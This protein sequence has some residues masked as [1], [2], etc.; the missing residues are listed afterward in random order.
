M[1]QRSQCLAY[2]AKK[3]NY[4]TRDVYEESASSTTSFEQFL[5]S[6][7]IKLTASQSYSLLFIFVKHCILKHCQQLNF[8]DEDT[9]KNLLQ[10]KLD[11][12]KSHDAS[13]SLQCVNMRLITIEQ[14]QKAI[15]K[16]LEQKILNTQELD[17]LK[18]IY[19]DLN[20]SDISSKVDETTQGRHTRKI[21]KSSSIQETATEQEII[22]PPKQFKLN[23]TGKIPTRQIG[24]YRVLEE[25]GTGGMGKVYKAYHPQEDKTVA[26]KVML[27]NSEISPQERNRFYAEAQ[28]TAKLQHDNIVKVY[29][30]KMEDDMDYIVMDFVDGVPLSLILKNTK[31]SLRRSLEIIKEV[32][33]AMDYAH[34]KGV[35]HR[36]LKPSNLMV[37]NRTGRP[38]IMDFGLAKNTELSTEVT[39][40]GAILGTPRYMAP[41]QASGKNKKVGPSTDVYALGAILYLMI[42][43]VPAVRGDNPAKI[44]YNVLHEDIISPKKYNNRLPAKV[45]T[46][47]MT[48]LQKSPQDRYSSAGA[49]AEDID[50]YL[51]GEM[52]SSPGVTIWQQSSKTFKKHRPFILLMMLLIPLSAMC[53]FLIYKTIINAGEVRALQKMHTKAVAENQIKGFEA[54]GDL[55]WEKGFYQRAC[56]FYTKAL[57]HAEELQQKEP[58]SQLREKLAYRYSLIPKCEKIIYMK[59]DINAM[60]FSPKT[61]LFVTVG[62]NGQMTI[63]NDPQNA[64]WDKVASSLYDIDF[65]PDGKTM[66]TAGKSYVYIWN[67]TTGKVIGKISGESPFLQAKYHFNGKSFITLEADNNIKVWDTQSLT[68]S[69]QMPPI[70][71]KPLSK[72]V[73]DKTTDSFF[74][75]T[76]DGWL[77]ACNLQSQK[78]VPIRL[79]SSSAVRFMIAKEKSIV[80]CGENGILKLFSPAILRYQLILPGLGGRIY[81]ADV[82]E[83]QSYL[84]VGTHDNKIHIFD[85]YQQKTEFIL[86]GHEDV[87]VA[88]KVHDNGEYMASFSND[89]TLRLWKFDK[90]THRRIV[91]QRNYPA[92]GIEFLSSK[93][94]FIT[95]NGNGHIQLWN[96][97]G[98]LQQTIKTNLARYA[99]AV[100]PSQK[101]VA[102]SG[103]ID[104]QEFDLTTQQKLFGFRANTQ[105]IF[106]LT[107]V[108]KNN[109]LVTDK[110]SAYVRSASNTKKIY[111]GNAWAYSSDYNNAT[112]TFAYCAGRVVSLW[113]A[114]QLKEIGTINVK[115]AGVISVAFNK[116]GSLIATG[117]SDGTIKIWSAKDFTLQKNLFFH[118][119]TIRDMA[120]F[121]ENELTAVDTQG[122]LSLWNV[123]KGICKIYFKNHT[124]GSTCVSFGRNKNIIAS[125]STDKSIVIRKLQIDEDIL[126]LPIT[127]LSTYIE[128]NI[129]MRIDNHLEIVPLDGNWK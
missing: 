48:A 80:S 67:T 43:G 113:N 27:R 11:N 28:L 3:L 55:E 123:E 16:L 53:A 17:I 60:A 83:E 5:V 99:M 72:L 115:T 75:T 109:L 51:Q 13:Y 2:F 119:F 77:Y 91:P 76:Q 79:F 56:L 110:N 86:E 122:F 125:G 64:K 69:R 100:A 45:E 74:T 66:I 22:A 81:S 26:I 59:S 90:G 49:F 107:Y 92:Y 37:N 4:I 117:L 44:I 21:V 62:N 33:L 18:K 31:L 103:L 42:A 63:V 106:S 8:L 98:E 120:F 1:D 35:I 29:D 116:S 38:I 87:V 12:L 47:C 73:C 25:I 78:V 50:R 104:V 97:N 54:K 32:A 39:K 127:K 70:T 58:I 94:Q 84:A 93:N 7:Q 57:Q 71:N 19:K 129:K 96:Q 68:V 52:L 126:R 24:P 61:P 46:I 30:V 114:E 111:T 102:V 36:D 23:T 101:K 121:G 82:D 15:E 14:A 89:Q 20:L 118:N 65:H 6:H 10:E 9:C 88:L 95:C 105:R 128:N 85:T 108:G 41:E 124:E 34:N 40:S 112:K